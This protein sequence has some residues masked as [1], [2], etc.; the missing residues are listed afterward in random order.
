[1][2][3]S[4]RLGLTLI[5]LLG[6]SARAEIALEGVQWQLVRREPGKALKPPTAENLS[7]LPVEPGG[8]LKGRLWARLKLLN[9]GPELDAILVRYSVSA[10]IAPLDK[11]Q[12]ASWALPFMLGDRRLPKVRANAPLEI[13][14]DPSDD[15]GLYLKNIFREGYW[16]DELKIEVMVQ[17][18]RDQKTPLKVLESILPLKAPGK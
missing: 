8:R 15:V 4:L 18:R 10:K 6:A 16:P 7:E 13:P 17:P 11:R 12:P 9:R 3:N 2:G 5:A 14:L 1:M